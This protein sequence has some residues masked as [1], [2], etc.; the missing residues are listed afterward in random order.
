MTLPDR[1]NQP[2]V[3]SFA[4]DPVDAPDATPANDSTVAVTARRADFTPSRLHV[5]GAKYALLGVWVLLAAVFAIAKPSTFLSLSSA[6]AIFGSQAALVFLAISAL[7]TFVVG[8]FDLSFAAVMGL[9]ATII[10]VLAGLH[11][12]NIALSCVIALAVSLGCGVLN[13][14]F[15]VRL[16]VPSL[17]VTLGTSSLFLGLSELISSSNTVSVSNR[18]FGKIALHNLFGL[19]LSFD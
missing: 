2:L 16:G 7:C 13:A 17:V 14:F 11:H 3:D 9:S 5:V 18:A 15:I 1:N 6:Q 8:E 12:V 19:P 10:A 4:L